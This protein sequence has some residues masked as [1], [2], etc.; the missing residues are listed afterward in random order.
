MAATKITGHDVNNIKGCLNYFLLKKK[1]EL[2]SEATKEFPSKRKL[3]KL[4]TLINSIEET[5][6]K[7]E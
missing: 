6:H 4:T 2:A 3:E 1:T 7:I 5:K